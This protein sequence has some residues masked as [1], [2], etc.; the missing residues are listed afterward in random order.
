MSP[1]ATSSS[2]AP[3]ADGATDFV[4]SPA[5][6]SALRRLK[7]L[8]T[9]AEASFDRIARLATKILDVPIAL[10]SLVDVNRQ[11]F[12]SCIGLPEP[13]S[14]WRETPLGMSFC[15]HVVAGG[16][17][18]VLSD[19]REHA[20]Y[21]DND[22]IPDLGVVAYLGCPLIVDGEVMGTF[23]VID[24]EP[25]GWTDAEIGIVRD[26]TELVMT[27]IRL[28]AESDERAA[29][30]AARD[31]V[32]AIVSHD[33]RAPLQTMLTSAALLDLDDP[34]DEQK[35]TIETLHRAAARM[36][37]LVGD[38][39]QVTSLDFERLSIEPEPIS[40][41]AFVDEL[42]DDARAAAGERGLEL[43]VNAPPLPRINA[44]RE[45]LAQAV[46]NLL[47]NAMRL[48]PSGGR[49][50]ISAQ[51]GAGEVVLSIA[52]TGPG[53]P[54]EDLPFLFDWSWHAGRD[55]KGGTGLGLSIAKGIVTAHGGTI[56][57]E[58][59]DGGGARFSIAL[60]TMDD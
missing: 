21:R 50:E 9:P 37:R 24:T 28:R 59:R 11:F 17:P 6:L 42:A 51:S 2:D 57:A 52:D 31:R 44:D 26:L 23:C 19:V 5:R 56:R 22:A 38:L 47:D 3:D 55:K 25:H 10:V 7:L 60:P 45:R 20:D 8:D 14:S 48:T 53:I 1:P 16:E 58:N 29:A 12:K 4:R 40:V 54:E 43:A 27:E 34:D 35:R 33:L 41:P 46:M 32:L 18:L 30:L 13:Y 39:L 15:K 36:N 49:V